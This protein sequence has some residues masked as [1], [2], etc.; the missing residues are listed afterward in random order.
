MNQL[1][2]D[3]ITIALPGQR[4]SK[5]DKAERMCGLQPLAFSP[6]KITVLSPSLVNANLISRVSGTEDEH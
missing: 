4:T 1:Y 3:K 6:V 2:V 5:R